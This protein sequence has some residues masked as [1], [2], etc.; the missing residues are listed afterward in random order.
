MR[1][2]KLTTQCVVEFISVLQGDERLDHFAGHRRGHADHRGLGHC[3]MLHQHVLH[4]ER[5][6]QVSGGFDDVVGTSDEPVV[7]VGVSGGEV[8]PG[9]VQIV[10]EAVPVAF[11]VV[12][13]TAEHRRPPC[14]KGQFPPDLVRGIDDGDAVVCASLHEARVDA[15]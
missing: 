5:A 14:A 8:P 15:R 10:D 1:A 4:L 12:Q 6:D 7:A 9:E 3:G 11:G 13:V 2:E